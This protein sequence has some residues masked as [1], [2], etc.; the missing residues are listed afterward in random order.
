MLPAPSSGGF[1]NFFHCIKRQMKLPTFDKN[2]A[3]M[4]KKNRSEKS[5]NLSSKI[6]KRK[7][8]IA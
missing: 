6:A 4:K 7:L 2:I 5:P 8:K 1:M 3:K